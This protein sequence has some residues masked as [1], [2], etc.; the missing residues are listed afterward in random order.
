V[1]LLQKGR[2]FG[3]IMKSATEKRYR[4]GHFVAEIDGSSR[5]VAKNL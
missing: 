1:L 4:P 5:K 2:K 3:Q